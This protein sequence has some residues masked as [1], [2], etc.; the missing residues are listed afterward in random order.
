MRYQESAERIGTLVA[1][2]IFGRGQ[3]ARGPIVEGIVTGEGL[4][5]LLRAIE[6]QRFWRL[7]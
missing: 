1:L 4:G 5:E 3:H 2:K 7:G 6:R